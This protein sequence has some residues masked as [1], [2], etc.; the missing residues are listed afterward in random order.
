M[1]MLRDLRVPPGGR[2]EAKDRITELE[3]ERDAM[4]PWALL[5]KKCFNESRGSEQRDV[6]GEVLQD[7]A[8]ALGLFEYVMVGEPCGDRCYCEDYFGRDEWPVQCLRLSALG[9]EMP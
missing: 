9:K 2:G 6:D 1:N 8:I 7:A 4:K 3:A 5:G